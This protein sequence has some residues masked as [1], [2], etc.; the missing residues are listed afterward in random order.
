MQP[1][2][3]QSKV[4]LSVISTFFGSKTPYKKQDETQKLFLEDLM[5]LTAKGFFLLSTCEN[6]WMQRLTL[7]LDPKVVFPFR[8][9]LSIEILPNMV[10]HCL[11]LHVQP[12]L[13][14]H[15]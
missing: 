1:T 4:A 11:K 12:L 14:P 7:R 13:M 8:K 15:L 10:T 3:K 9:T 5:L 2:K 6:V